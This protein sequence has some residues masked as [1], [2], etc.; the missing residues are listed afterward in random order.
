[1][2]EVL[3]NLESR[4]VTTFITLTSCQR[5]WNYYLTIFSVTCITWIF[6]LFGR[7]K[8]DIRDFQYVYK[9][10]KLITEAFRDYLMIKKRDCL[11]SFFKAVFMHVRLYK[12][13]WHGTNEFDKL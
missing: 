13:A 1:M 3:D 11:N 10:L 7:F 4:W 12:I 5:S 2:N 9:G 8:M 6:N